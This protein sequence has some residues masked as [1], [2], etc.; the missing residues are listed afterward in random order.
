MPMEDVNREMGR[1]D[2]RVSALESRADR[3]ESAINAGLALVNKKL[4][5]VQT[6]LNQ[7]KGGI[8]VFHVIA[9]L[10]VALASV[11]LGAHLPH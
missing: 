3:F 5:D 8:K 10:T 7:G 1:L 4:D 11:L 2:G 9:G 6:T